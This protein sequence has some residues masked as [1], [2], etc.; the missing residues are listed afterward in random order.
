MFDACYNN[1]VIR[2]DKIAAQTVKMV[3]K[4]RCLILD[5]RCVLNKLL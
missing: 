4:I 1:F 5:N 2:A 3:K